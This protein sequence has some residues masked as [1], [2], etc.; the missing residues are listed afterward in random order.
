MSRVVD[1]IVLALGSIIFKRKRMID[2]V[3]CREKYRTIRGA[4]PFLSV[5]AAISLSGCLQ[6]SEVVETEGGVIGSGGGPT[7][8]IYELKNLPSR[9]SP[10]IP[11]TLLKGEELAPSQPENRDVVKEK[12]STRMV[13]G[14][15]GKAE[16]WRRMNAQLEESSLMRVNAEINS[17]IIDIAFDDIQAMCEDQPMNCTIPA[18]Q[19]K[20]K[21]TQN[22]IN[23]LIEVSKDWVESLPSE[24]LNDF[25]RMDAAA[26]I[27]EQFTSL[28]DSEVVLGE[29]D[30]SQLD[31]APYHHSVRTFLKRSAVSDP[32]FTSLLWKDEE[33]DARW[34]DDG[35]VAKFVFDA[36][37]APTREY[38]YQNGIP[39]EIVIATA[40]T[41]FDDGRRL[42]G[43]VKILA[44]DPTNAGVLVEIAR[45]GTV[46]VFVDDE[47]FARLDHGLVQG[48]MDSGGGY[49]VFDGISFILAETP[50]AVGYTGL[51]E[52]FDN[53]GNLIAVTGC[54]ARVSPQ[55]FEICDE[56]DFVPTGPIGSSIID[57]PYFFQSGEFDSL[58]AVNDAI[59]WTVEGLPIEI[60]EFAVVPADS[61]IE[62]S[63]RELLCRGFQSLGDEV[64]IFC[65][66]TD[67]QLDNTVVL[68]LVDGKPGNIIP[69]ATLVQIQ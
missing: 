51:R 31:G 25:E 42:F 62:L 4:L 3:N 13:D 69:T 41:P 19:V 34:R 40:E 61:A 22:V 59:R 28:L 32:D 47:P 55:G 6:G 23:R 60:K 33:F 65:S 5:L 44:S 18:D 63:E 68:E 20:V 27:T 39:S 52:S 17:T 48:R 14:N 67:E 50:R 58:L 9:I 1:E 10:D 66:A 49:S 57:S 11:K 7:A 35:D 12:I 15:F 64:R 8:G 53:V 37:N 46:P 21:L 26:L 54:N 38:F 2:S 56:E 29:T 45:A 16:G 24:T 43:H 30:Y 36:A